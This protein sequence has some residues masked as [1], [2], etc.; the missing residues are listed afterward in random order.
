MVWRISE[1]HTGDTA[2]MLIQVIF[3]SLAG[4]MGAM[5][6][7]FGDQLLLTK[8]SARWK[9]PL[10]QMFVNATGSCAAGFVASL[11]VSALPGSVS[12]IILTG[13]LGGFTTLSAASL[14]TAIRVRNRAWGAATVIGVG[15]LILCIAAAFFGAA[16]GS[17]LTFE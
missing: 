13:F 6:R 8:T 9:L 10:S 5:L 17:S 4:G 1:N 7:F 3:I 2:I 11:A 16:L 12:P 14:E 15:Q